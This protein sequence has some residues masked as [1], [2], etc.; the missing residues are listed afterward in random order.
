MEL[1]CRI[2]GHGRFYFSSINDN[3]TWNILDAGLVMYSIAEFVIYF[4][5]SESNM[6]CQMHLGSVVKTIKMLRVI[7]VVRLFRFF[8]EL[9][10][11]VLMIVDSM[12]SLGW[13]LFMLAIIIYVF[14][15]IFTQSA[16]KWLEEADVCGGMPVDTA[17]DVERYFGNILRT[18]Y[19]LVQAMMG[20]V[21]WGILSDVLLVDMQDPLSAA[22]FF[23][24]LAF[25]ILAVLNI[26]TGAFVDTAVETARTQRDFLIEK[27]LALKEQYAQQMRS[28]FGAMDKDGSGTLHYAEMHEY[29][30]DPRVQG[31]F[32]A[33]GLETSD[34][35]RLFGLID[36]DNSGDVDVGEFLEGFL[37]LKGN[38]RSIDVYSIMRDL[39]LLDG[40]V[41]ALCKAVDNFW[42]FL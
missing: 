38:A 13:A 22:F 40:R 20:G 27:E 17:S 32:S 24:Y 11:L 3:R 33:L 16:V 23:F 12:K 10:I 34:A 25:T 26:I 15:I 2:A 39:K 31:Y 19:S 36:V 7:K 6:N 9:S 29:M 35:E 1:C 42:T 14:A 8:R 41:E 21:S 4:A 30:Q 5:H 18:V 28:L 37:R